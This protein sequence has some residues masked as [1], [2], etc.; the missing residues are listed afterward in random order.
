MNPPLVWPYWAAI[1]GRDDLHFLNALDRRRALLTLLVSNGVA[2]GRTIKEIF[3]RHG[4]PAIDARVEL[5]AAEHR[6]AVGLHREGSRAESEG[7]PR[8]GAHRTP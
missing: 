6:V 3:C 4:L 1:G 8:P 5:A 2:E 7:R